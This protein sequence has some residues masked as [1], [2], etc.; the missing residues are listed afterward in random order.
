[1]ND[2]NRTRKKTC[3]FRFLPLFLS[4]LLF[5]NLLVAQQKKITGNITDADNN[6][7]E[8]VSVSVKNKPAIGTLSDARGNFTLAVSVGDVLVFEFVGYQKEEM[9]VGS[10][11]NLVV[12]LLPRETK[13]N[14]VVVIGYGTKLKGELTGS[15]AKVDNKAFETRP[16]TN[17]MNALQGALPGVTVT[18]GSGRPGN[19]NYSLQIRGAS[20]VSGSKVLVLI[21][22]IPGDLSLINPN[23]IAELTVLKDAAASIYGARAADGVVIVTTKKGRKGAPAILYSGNYGIKKPRFLKRRTNTLQLA[24]MYDEGMRNVNQP[25]VSEEV[26]AKIRA[27][28]E[29]DPTGWLKYLENFPGFY[30]SHDWIDDVFGTGVQQMHNLSISGGGDHNAY[31]FSAGYER[32]EGV[33]RYGKNYSDRY[34]LRMN[35]D[36]RFSD[37]LNVETRTSFENQPTIEPTAV[38]SVLYFVNQMGSYVPIYNPQGQLYKYQGGF[39]NPIQYLQEAGVN[40]TNAYRL[41]TNIKG[42]LQ[43]WKDLKLVGQVGVRMDFDDGKRTNP[44]FAQHNWDGSNFDI[45]NV[46]NSAVFSNSKSLYQNYTA[47]LDYNKTLLDKHRLNVMAGASRER[48]DYQGQSITGYNFASN[49]IFTLNLADRTKTQYANFTGNASDWAL[50]SY[51]GR[52]SYSFDRKYLVDF[53]TR[54]DGSSKFA[55][56]KRWSALFPS[57]AVAWNLSEEQF[58]RSLDL[59]NNLKARLSWGKSGNQELSFGDYD[60][61]SLIAISGAYPM[62]SPNVGLPGA[63]SSIASE[64]RTWETIEARNAGIDIAVLDSRLTGSF[65]YYIKNNRNMLVNDQ[66]PATLGGAAPTQNIGKL[67]TKGWDFLIGW[68]DRI[69]DF[70]YSISAMLSDSKNKLVELKGNDAYGEG[71]VH[72]RKGY[73]LDS[74]FGYQFDGLIQNAEQLAAYRQLGNV[75]ADLGVGDVMFRDVDGDGKITAFGDP[76]KGT[77]GDMVYLGNLLPRY[78]Y[79]SNINVSYKGF[80]LNIFLQ[81]IGKREGIRTG[82]FSY[83]FTSVWMQPLEYFYGKNWTPENPTAKYPRIIPGAVG[84]DGIRNW[85]WRYSSMRMNNLAYLKLKVLTLAYNLPQT[86]VRKAKM[87]NVRVYVS[88]QDLITFSKDTWNR[89]FDPEETWER[90]DEQT[91]PFNSVISFGLDIKF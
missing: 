8:Q 51:F 19:E 65:D 1:M 38:G 64:N 15:V 13:L 35:Y 20:S 53:T 24:E 67:E 33:F 44:T 69:G 77:G 16:L 34:N 36:F 57:V 26:F 74:Y 37:R 66:L 21:D 61:I 23:D 25:G 88:G 17:A 22:G 11:S 14:E 73:S 3:S 84:Y 58:I 79:S 28:A 4:F 5:S 30:Q 90:S 86:W 45:A 46:P 50:Q 82:E 27:N 80:D 70:R 54:M 75:P 68:N 63:V 71:L 39:R 49:E 72:A 40:K 76:A 43:V 87:Q 47:Y 12:K 89:S 10:N 60:Y 9:S 6:P 7:L 55:Q 18:R 78:V 52:L 85:N 42:N 32:N 91:Y 56:N 48:N 2:Q 83:P 29:P 62:G 81:G 31:L 41:S 59:F